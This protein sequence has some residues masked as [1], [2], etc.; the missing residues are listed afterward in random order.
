MDLNSKARQP[1]AESNGKTL[2]TNYITPISTNL[3]SVKK[4]I[5]FSKPKGS[6]AL[7]CL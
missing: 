1:Q 6:Y 7:Q 5:Y 2:S 4:P 3:F